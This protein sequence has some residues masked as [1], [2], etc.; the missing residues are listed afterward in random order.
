MTTIRKMLRRDADAVRAIE[1]SAFGAWHREA[2]GKEKALPRRTRANILALL[3]RD[4]EGCF[5][6]ESDGRVIGFIFSRTWGS[7]G[8]FGTFA[9]LPDY[10]GT[11]LGKRLVTASADYLKQRPDRV[12]GLETMPESAYNLGFYLRQ[13]FEGRFLSLQLVKALEAAGAQR[14]DVLRWSRLEAAERDVAL[15]QL[16]GITDRIR[17]GLDYSKEVLATQRNGSGDT[18]FLMAD[19]RMVG[20]C[21]VLLVGKREGED[22]DEATAHVS[23]L[24]PGETSVETLGAL[25]SAA[26]SLA[27]DDGKRSMMVPVNTRHVRAVRWLLQLSYRVKRA[28]VCMVLAGTDAGPETDGLVDLS[29]WAG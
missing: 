9:V 21:V 18:L 29:L 15:A 11:G 19:G 8:W 3:E 23:V 20:A 27:A 14:E 12:I 1:A 6:T 7:V 13:G 4:P 17:P 26:E 24:D 16:R 28:R 2:K 22:A 5:V 25:L 10:Q